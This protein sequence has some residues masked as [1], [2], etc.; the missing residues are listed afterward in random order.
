MTK[1]AICTF[2]AKVV[3]DASCIRAI[4]YCRF[5]YDIFFSH[6]TL[7][8]MMDDSLAGHSLRMMSEGC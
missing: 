3:G 6:F 4:A 7:R 2:K 1:F 8:S 5:L